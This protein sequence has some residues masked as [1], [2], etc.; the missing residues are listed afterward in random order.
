MENFKAFNIRVP[1]ELWVFMKML[2]AQQER[3]MTE[4][5]IECLND[6]KRKNIKKLTNSEDKKNASV[7]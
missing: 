1:R 2:A 6:Y 5:V 3:S 7:S 4:L